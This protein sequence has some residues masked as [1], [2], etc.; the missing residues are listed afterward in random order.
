MSKKRFKVGDVVQLRSGGPLMTIDALKVDSDKKAVRCTWFID[1]R[2]ESS[3]F[4]PKT[5]K[6]A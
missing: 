6:P 5:L 3:L 1:G 2:L 4:H